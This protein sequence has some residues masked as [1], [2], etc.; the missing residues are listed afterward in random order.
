MTALERV[1][2]KLVLYNASATLSN[3]SIIWSGI[4]SAYV[5]LQSNLTLTCG[6]SFHQFTAGLNYPQRED[7]TWKRCKRFDDSEYVAQRWNLTIQN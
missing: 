6:M 5:G 1:L 3:S 7:I 4:R 2:L